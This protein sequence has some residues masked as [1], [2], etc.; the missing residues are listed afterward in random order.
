MNSIVIQNLS[1]QYKFSPERKDIYTK[2]S[3]KDDLVNLWEGQFGLFF[4]DFLKDFKINFL[5]K[6]KSLLCGL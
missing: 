5:S 3:L 2:K 6:K 4:Q 1:K